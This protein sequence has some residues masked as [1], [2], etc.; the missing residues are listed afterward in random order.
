VQVQYR[1]HHPTKGNQG[2]AEDTTRTGQ[3]L[4]PIFAIGHRCASFFSEFFYHKIS[5]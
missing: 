3:V 2:T 4:R 5:E 1:P